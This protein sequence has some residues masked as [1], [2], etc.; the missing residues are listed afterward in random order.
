MYTK[1][2]VIDSGIGGVTVLKECIKSV[3]DFEYLYY[4]DSIH[5]PYGDKSGDEVIEITKNIVDELISRGCR[6]I[7]IACNTA[8]AIAVQYLRSNYSDIQF[9]AIEPAIKLVYDC[10]LDGTLI[11]AT[12]GTMDSEKFKNLYDKYHHDNFYLLSCVGLANL[13]ENGDYDEII[14]YLKK[15]LSFYS[16]K[17]SNVVLGCTHYPLIKREISSVLGD[18]NFYDGSYGVAKQLKRIID[19]YGY[20]GSNN[21]I[22][23]KD[24]TGDVE[25]MKRFYQ[26]LESD[27]CE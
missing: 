7:I 21:K 20:I 13:I 18:V 19:N 26:I 23:F 6:I 5:N 11:M 3:P 14:N 15:N 2:G 24:S 27:I 22:L 16:G 8:S 12:K 4:S 10:S 17:V 25:K 1:I 9:I